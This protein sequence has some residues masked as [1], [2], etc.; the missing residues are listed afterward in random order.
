MTSY[1]ITLELSLRAIKFILI[2]AI[3][4]RR[5]NFFFSENLHKAVLY[6]GYGFCYL[7]FE[8]VKSYSAPTG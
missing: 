5:F 8:A 4:G 7:L 6:Y 3:R 1:K 2:S